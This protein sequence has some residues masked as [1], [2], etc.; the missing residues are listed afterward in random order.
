VKDDRLHHLVARALQSRRS[1][2]QVLGLAAPGSRGLGQ[3]PLRRSDFFAWVVGAPRASVTGTIR[4]NGE[5]LA[6]RGVG[7]HDDN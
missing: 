4:V 5:T 7:Y 6:M 3:H 1:P 2:L